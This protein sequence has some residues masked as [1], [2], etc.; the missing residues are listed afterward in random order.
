[1]TEVK[2]ESPASI[3]RLTE[4]TIP[5]SLNCR[6]CGKNFKPK[7]SRRS[8]TGYS[9]FCSIACLYKSL[10]KNHPSKECLEQLYY[11]ES[12]TQEEIAR[13]LNLSRCLIAKL[14]KTYNLRCR[15]RSEC[16]A[17]CHK[18]GDFNNNP[19]LAPGA[20]HYNWKGEN[21][22]VIRP[23]GY[24]YVRVPEDYPYSKAYP[25]R[26]LTEHR[27]IWET[28]HQK[29]LPKGWEIHHINGIKTD[30]RIENLKAYTKATHARVMSI[31]AKKICLLEQRIT[32]LEAEIVLLRACLE[33]NQSIFYL[34][35]SYGSKD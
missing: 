2:L 10:L 5:D 22:R 9:I 7:F 31:N 18:R 15:S 13:K 34:G 4:I 35:G 19:L 6:N 21:Y 24:V 28:Y 25:G 16:L 11:G 33:K 8:R 20:A 30:N 14:M 17:L 1:M 29:V 26:L 3:S 23:D 27:V 32:Q 12:L